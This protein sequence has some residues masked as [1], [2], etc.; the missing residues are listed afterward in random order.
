MVCLSST[1]QELRDCLHISFTVSE[2]CA[3]Y[4]FFVAR[5]DEFRDYLKDLE[6][7]SDIA[8]KQQ[9][10]SFFQTTFQPI[11]E[12]VVANQSSKEVLLS[13]AKGI[14]SLYDLLREDRGMQS[15]RIMHRTWYVTAGNTRQLQLAKCSS[16]FH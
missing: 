2:L 6:A 9:L 13:V 14:C 15:W 8:Q 1:V 3:G 12:S 5:L 11:C 10:L 7:S 4:D 16:E